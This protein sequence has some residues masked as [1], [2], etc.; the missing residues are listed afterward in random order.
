MMIEVGA[1]AVQIHGCTYKC[2]PNNFDQK[3]SVSMH[4]HIVYLG[5]V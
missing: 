1:D 2:T 5:L 3:I 4:I